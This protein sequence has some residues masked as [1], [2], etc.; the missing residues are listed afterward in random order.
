MQE[1]RNNFKSTTGN[2]IYGIKEGQMPHVRDAINFIDT[3]WAKVPVSA[4]VRCWLKSK[5]LA[6]A[7]EHK[8][9]KLLP[10]NNSSVLIEEKPIDTEEAR[11]LLCGR[12]LLNLSPI[13]DSP[14]V[15]LI[16]DVNAY[17]SPS[18]MHTIINN[19][20]PDERRLQGGLAAS[21]IQDLFDNQDGNEE[22]TSINEVEDQSMT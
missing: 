2:G 14:L 16:N 1:S 15:D 22:H 8:L 18:S 4:I 5:C 11:Q 21:E 10:A 6:L 9:R 3:A 7:H 17:D 20:A 12:S 19:P 13:P